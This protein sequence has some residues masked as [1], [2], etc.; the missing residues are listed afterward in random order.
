MSR[1]YARY[2]NPTSESR[3]VVIHLGSQ[4][5]SRQYPH[6]AALKT[7]FERKG[8]DLALLAAPFDQLPS[9]VVEAEVKRML[10]EPVLSEFRSASLVITN[11]S[12]PMHLS[13]LLGCPT[14]TIARISN[15]AEWVPPS[16]ITVSSRM[17]P[18]GYRPDR[19]YNTDDVVEGWPE[20]D[21]VFEHVLSILAKIKS[22]RTPER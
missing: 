15:I 7:L 9:G 13:A 4:W 20:P 16:V 17:M 18:R 2:C 3:H 5:R 22:A 10:D 12:A 21:L 19:S 11:D 6:V 8:I 14:L 1:N